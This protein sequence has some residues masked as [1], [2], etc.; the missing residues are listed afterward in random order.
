MLL[1]ARLSDVIALLS[2][3]I[4]NISGVSQEGIYVR[5]F[6]IGLATHVHIGRTAATILAPATPRSFD[7]RLRLV[8]APLSQTGIS[9][10]TG[11]RKYC[12]TY[13]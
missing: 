4:R 3:D 6:V 10:I 12:S 1:L 9:V 13:I 8:I 2:E 7:A 11:M 5:L